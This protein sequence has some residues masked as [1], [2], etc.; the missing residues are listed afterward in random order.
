MKT[1]FSDFYYFSE[2]FDEK[3]IKKT[4]DMI[5][6]NNY[7]FYKGRTGY[8]KEDDRD[9]NNRNI[10]YVPQ[11]NEESKWIYELLWDLTLEA[12]EK[13]YHF[14][15]NKVT[16]QLHY[17]IYPSDGGHLDW[18]MD[19]GQGDVNKR[20]LA[21][22]V[23][24]CDPDDYEGGD[25]QCWSG[26]LNGFATLPRK[27]GDVLVMPSFMMH[28]VTPIKSGERRALVFWTGSDRPFR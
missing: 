3:L 12:N 20:K 17:V 21:L 28:R 14:D 2:Y 8:Q 25:F 7:K 9:S 19:I 5:Y 22:T 10:C 15:I 6:S 18:H 11:R 23:Q 26:A 27:K 1:N 16:D 13:L 24:L 4:N